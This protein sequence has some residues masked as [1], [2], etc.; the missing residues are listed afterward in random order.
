MIDKIIPYGR[1]HITDEDIQAVVETLK[2]DYLTQGP[3]IKE[4]EIKFAEYVGAKYAVAVNNA[5]AGLHLSATVLGVKPGHKIIVTPMTFA[6]SANC[7]RYCGGEVVF[8]DID[9]DTYLMDIHKLKA[10]LK[11]AP[12]GTYKGIVPVDFAGYPLNLEAFRELADEYGLWIMEDACHAPGGYFLDS[13]GN[14][15]YCG[16]GNFADLAVFS[17]HPVKH[18]ATGEGGMVTTNSKELYD[19]LCLYRTHG[20]T[21]DP[22]KLHEHHGGWY[23]EMQELGYNYRL[24]DF[25]AAL[26]VSQLKRAAEGLDRRHQLVMRYNEAF[27]IVEGIKIP[28]NA[29]D[30]YHAYHLYII[31]VA[32]RKGLYDYLYEN[33]IYAQ[34][35]YVPLHLMPYYRQFGNKKGDLPVVEEYSEHCLS[36]PMYPTLTDEEQKYIINIVLKFVQK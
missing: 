10:M 20:I 4:F 35:H 33:N 26:G 32:D 34:V 18:I 22:T 3:K 23:Y 7:I 16:N 36:L 9:K 25:Q 11:A 19:K 21:K 15:Q 27:S 14:K 28:Y 13:N 24:T 29:D 17:F 12:K 1:Q 2:S 6:A 5:T 30:V 8:C 31:Q